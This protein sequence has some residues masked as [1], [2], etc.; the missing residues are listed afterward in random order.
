[1]GLYADMH[2]DPN[3]KK[4][5]RQT[6]S[7]KETERLLRME[8]IDAQAIIEQHKQI[9]AATHKSDQEAASPR[10]R[11]RT[12]SMIPDSPTK[13]TGFDSL[14]ATQNR[15]GKSPEGSPTNRTFDGGLGVLSRVR[16][17]AK[18][19]LIGSEVQLSPKNATSP[20]LHPGFMAGN[21]PGASPR[22][23]NK[24][25]KT[26]GQLPDRSKSHSPSKTTEMPR[27]PEEG[28]R[29]ANEAGAPGRRRLQPVIDTS[30]QDPGKFRSPREVEM[31]INPDNAY[32][33]SPTM[34]ATL[35]VGNEMMSPMEKF[36][37][38]RS[39]NASPMKKA[40]EREVP[41][42]QRQPQQQWM[43]K[44][45]INNNIP[46]QMQQKIDFSMSPAV[47]IATNDN[48]NESLQ[49]MITAPNTQKNSQERNVIG[50]SPLPKGVYS[51]WANN[52]RQG[53][54]I[55]REISPT[56]KET[57]VFSMRS[58]FG[59]M[60]DEINPERSPLVVLPRD[61]NPL[62]NQPNII[63][64][65]RARS[66]SPA[67]NLIA[68]NNLSR[69]L[70]V[71]GEN[72]TGPALNKNANAAPPL[73]QTLLQSQRNAANQKLSYQK[74]IPGGINLAKL[75]NQLSSTLNQK[76]NI[77]SDGK[78]IPG[79]NGRGDIIDQLF[80]MPKA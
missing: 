22:G 71:A 56:K 17:K 32:F 10:G 25:G 20:Y 12:M 34:K 47:E 51:D 41:S 43:D 35:N 53:A 49:L 48:S 57:Q 72:I 21:S 58:R 77:K 69:N 18:T 80:A 6:I 46:L 52:D 45:R 50:Q 16:E 11:K 78:P 28:N 26:E 65:D 36:L 4:K 75:Q 23:D 19:I 3:L 61:K 15:E 27:F 70:A 9:L 79:N 42:P 62:A 7:T 24:Y 38:G 59:S 63:K 14:N 31:R 29:N 74:I 30:Y 73:I 64:Y 13:T 5:I 33:G 67:K 39:K 54:R 55:Q 60:D 76:V 37:A 2:G 68:P 40:Q 1:M 44:G 66:E 8:E